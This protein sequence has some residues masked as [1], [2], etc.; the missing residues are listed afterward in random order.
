MGRTFKQDLGDWG[1]QK[2]VDFLVGKG[3]E[4]IDRNVVLGKGEIDIIAWHNK[5]Y[6]GRTLCIIEVKTRS[7]GPGSAERATVGKKLSVLIRTARRYCSLKNIDV[8]STPIQF[9]QVSIYFDRK[10]GIMNIRLNEIFF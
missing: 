5:F 2:A 3:Y 8:D 7:Y 6:N 4:I 1:E 10:R 9:E